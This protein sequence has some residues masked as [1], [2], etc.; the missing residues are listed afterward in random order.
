MTLLLL[1]LLLLQTRSDPR[2]YWP[3]LDDNAGSTLL[4]WR[5]I[6]RAHRNRDAKFALSLAF[7]HAA[8]RRHIRIIASDSDTNVAISPNQVVSRIKRRPAQTRHQ[9]LN[10]CVRGPSQRTV[11]MSVLLAVK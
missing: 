8:C 2:K 3:G 4:R 5:S 10:P 9:G 1:L 11:F 6:R 7:I